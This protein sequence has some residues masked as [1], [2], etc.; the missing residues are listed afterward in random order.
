M[1]NKII[2]IIKYI[3]RYQSDNLKYEGRYEITVS[4]GIVSLER[5]LKHTRRS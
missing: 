5:G 3:R 1:Y 2:I 4:K